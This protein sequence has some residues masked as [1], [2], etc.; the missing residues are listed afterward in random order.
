MFLS[1]IRSQLHSDALY[2]RRMESSQKIKHP[3]RKN[4]FTY[5]RRRTGVG[6]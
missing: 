1:N 2:P 4:A 3:V 5:M 6:V